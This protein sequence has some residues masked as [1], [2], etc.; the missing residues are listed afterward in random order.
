MVLE[1]NS[2][3]KKLEVNG[4]IDMKGNEEMTIRFA[5]DSGK[6]FIDIHPID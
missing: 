6:Y 1:D 4:V 5:P 3:D 2:E